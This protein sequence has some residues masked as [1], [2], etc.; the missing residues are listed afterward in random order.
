MLLWELI[1]Q[2][3]LRIYS[4]VGTTIGS[5]DLTITLKEFNSVSENEIIY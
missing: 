5:G 3:L 1:Q 2:N 4:V